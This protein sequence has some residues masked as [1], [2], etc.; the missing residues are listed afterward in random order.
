MIG[1]ALVLLLLLLLGHR[2]RRRHRRMTLFLAELAATV[3][4][5]ERVVNQIDF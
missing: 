2:H 5:F 4:M 3:D 1:Q